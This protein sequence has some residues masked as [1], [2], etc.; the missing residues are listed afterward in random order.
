MPYIQAVKNMLRQ[1][2]N[3]Q[4]ITK[5]IK[6]SVLSTSKINFSNIKSSKINYKFRNLN[7]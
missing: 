4:S 5:L 2:P 3:V 7:Y 1:Y 6:E